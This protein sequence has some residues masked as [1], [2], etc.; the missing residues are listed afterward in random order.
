MNFLKT[1][2]ARIIVGIIWG[3]GLACI[4]KKTCEGRKC[5]VY[6]APNPHKVTKNI[7]SH[8]NKCYSYKTVTTN[9]TKDAY[10]A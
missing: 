4:F 8:N 3:L 2:I 7:Y 10:D 5:I 1:N 6:R 9:C